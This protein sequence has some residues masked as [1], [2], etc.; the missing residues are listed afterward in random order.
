[1]KI[2]YALMSCSANPRYTA[3]WPIVAAAWLKLG[4][5]PVCLF[6]PDNPS[7]KLPDAPGGIV[8]TIP[9]LNDVHIFIQTLMLRYWGSC[10]YPK[11]T[12]LVSDIDLLPLSHHFFHEQL[13]ACPEHAYA[14]LRNTPG[15]YTFHDLTNLP[16]KPASINNLRYLYGWFHIARGKIMHEVL[17]FTS[18][19]E[20]SCQKTIP[21]FLHKNSKITITNRPSYIGSKPYFGD[22][23]WTS[24]RLH[25]SAY[26][27]IHYISFP[28]DHY[29]GCITYYEIF[30]R[31]IQQ[32]GRYV[33]IHLSLPYSEC[34]EIIEHLLATG[35]L[36]KPR[37]IWVIIFLRRL[38][39]FA[40]YPNKKIK[41]VGPWLSFILMILLW[42]VLR[43]LR[44]L[45]LFKPYSKILA[46]GLGYKFSALLDQNPRLMRVYYQLVRAREFVLL[47]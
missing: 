38:I 15:K 32:G 44:M 34:K 29:L 28:R 22:E 36:P 47:K 39:Y 5:T 17:G 46:G 37:G 30:N 35:S 3:Y 21:Y 2:Q 8:H 9:P 13:T 10:L 26:Q 14:Y 45:G 4:V 23:I 11:S 19:W 20:T 12:V 16:E 40:G 41:I 42:C 1:M 18:N 24:V 6:I 33:G 7:V 43:M 31:D 27:P 25:H